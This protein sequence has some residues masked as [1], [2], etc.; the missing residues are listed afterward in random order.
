MDVGSYWQQAW[1]R[2]YADRPDRETSALTESSRPVKQGLWGRRIGPWD[3]LCK[4]GSK[5]YERWMW[6]A[7]G[8]RPGL[9]RTQTGQT[10]RLVHSQSRVAQT[11]SACG[12]D[13]LLFAT[14]SEWRIV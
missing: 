9:G 3:A 6:G 8:S 13:I 11:N 14:L 7:T 5:A 4:M 1:P 12:Y 2:P 10:G